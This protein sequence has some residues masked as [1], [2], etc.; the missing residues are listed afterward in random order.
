MEGAIHT[1]TSEMTALRGLAAVANLQASGAFD[2][3]VLFHQL[4]VADSV[5]VASLADFI[6]DQFGKL[7]VLV[8]NAGVSGVPLRP[9]ILSSFKQVRGGLTNYAKFIN[10]DLRHG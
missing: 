7:D 10:R 6:R 9:E 3:D 8:N 5:S 4:D 2:S 1:A